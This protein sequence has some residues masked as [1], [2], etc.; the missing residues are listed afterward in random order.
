MGGDDR[1]PAHGTSP[2][3]TGRDP[4]AIRSVALVA[5]VDHGKTTLVDG[6]LRQTG[7]FGAH[8]QPLERVFDQTYSDAKDNGH[9][10][11]EALS[12]AVT[13]VR[14]WFFAGKVR[15][16]LDDKPYT[17]YYGDFWDSVH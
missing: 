1:E 2:S 15:N 16:S 11:D 14:S 12:A 13:M 10:D 8:E 5:H 4:A 6:I 17:E 7:V 3:L 9:T